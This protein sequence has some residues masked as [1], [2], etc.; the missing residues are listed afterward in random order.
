MLTK[1]DIVPFAADKVVHFLA[2]LALAVPVWLTFAVLPFGRNMAAL[3]F[4]AGLLFSSLSGRLLN[5][6]SLWPAGRA[7][8]NTRSSAPC[9]PSRK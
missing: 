8:T 1:E 4:D 3:D 6:R 9:V 7:G 2:P 5:S